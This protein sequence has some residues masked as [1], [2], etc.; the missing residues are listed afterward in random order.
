MTTLDLDA[1]RLELRSDEGVRLTVYTD[2]KGIPTIGCGRNLR[3][4]GISQRI[5]DLLLEE[6]VAEC[7][8]DLRTFPWFDALDP[9]RQRALLNLRFNLGAGKLRTFR[10][11]LDAMSRKDYPAARRELETS[12]W[13]QQVQPSRR[14]RIASQILNGRDG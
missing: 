9:V 6:D 11:F 2:T 4:R 10:R 5:C 1:A 8:T 13:W 12:A 3:D 14:D 7:L